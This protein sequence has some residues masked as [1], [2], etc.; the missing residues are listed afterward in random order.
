M[1]NIY[2]VKDKRK[3]Q[4]SLEQKRLS[5]CRRITKHYYCAVFDNP[6]SRIEGRSFI[7]NAN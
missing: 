5:V 3:L 6:P 7:I 2:C 4:M 1:D